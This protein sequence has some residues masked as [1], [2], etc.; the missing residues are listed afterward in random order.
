MTR[1]GLYSAQAAAQYG[2]VIWSTPSGGEAEITAIGYPDLPYLWED[3]VKL[4]VVEYL[5]DGRDKTAPRT[6]SYCG[7]PRGKKDALVASSK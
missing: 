2:T 1:I 7:Y 4:E 3:A 5:R 6:R